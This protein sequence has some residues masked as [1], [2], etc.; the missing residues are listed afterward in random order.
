MRSL[1]WGPNEQLNSWSERTIEPVIAIHRPLIT[2]PSDN[3]GSIGVGLD[4]TAAA[5]ETGNGHEKRQ[6][7]QDEK[8]ADRLTRLSQ[9]W[10]EEKTILVSRGH[11]ALTGGSALR[12]GSLLHT[13][14]HSS[15]V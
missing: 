8:I 1:T 15:V 9:R 2:N 13:D 7:A 11:E 10:Q 6:T 3:G 5:T 12:N 14:Y 4:L